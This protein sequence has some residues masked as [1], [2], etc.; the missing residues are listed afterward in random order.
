[1]TAKFFFSHGGGKGWA[2]EG[3][4]TRIRS[5][6]RAREL[7]VHCF[8]PRRY[9]VICLNSCVVSLK[10]WIIQHHGPRVNHNQNAAVTLRISYKPYVRICLWHSSLPCH[11]HTCIP[12]YLL[13]DHPGQISVTARIP[14]W[15]KKLQH[16]LEG[17]KQGVW[18][19]LIPSDLSVLFYN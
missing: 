16:W 5:Y 10:Y 13:L 11:N 19:V 6:S 3:T 18:P 14:G 7:R 8:S 4:S 12:L 9:A 15:L 1:M 17:T 2:S